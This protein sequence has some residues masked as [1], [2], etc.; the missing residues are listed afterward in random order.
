MSKITLNKEVKLI[1]HFKKQLRPHEEFVLHHVFNNHTLHAPASYNENEICKYATKNGIAPLLHH[2]DATSS[3]TSDSNNYLK[4][5]HYQTLLNNTH[6]YETVKWIQQT[7]KKENINFLFLKGSLLAFTRYKD[8]AL[9]PMSDIDLIIEN[10]KAEKAYSLLMQ[11]GATG[12]EL[13]FTI[14]PNDHHLPP[15]RYNKNLIEVH[16]SLFP[17]NSKFNIKIIHLFKNKL[18][19]QKH[20]TAIEGPSVI[21]TATH[22]ALHLYYTFLRGGLRLSWF[23]D[24]YTLTDDLKTIDRN[25]FLSFSDK[26]Q[27][28]ESLSFVGSF[29][30]LIS[31]KTLPN[32]PLRKNYKPRKIDINRVIESFRANTQQN[33]KESYQLI[34][35]QIREASGIKN[36]ISIIQLRLTKNRSIKGLALIRHTGIVCYR[37]LA[38]AFNNIQK[39]LRIK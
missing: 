29:Y 18:I 10:N 4:Q 34:V 16:Q 39:T 13:P 24:L 19:W 28:T 33:T 21:H 5:R 37:F 14:A 12:R 23:Y 15:L 30:T 35:E 1:Q 38:Y 31:G 2:T 8:S 17:I 27:L 32:W 20:H 22:V 9:R 36:K 6:L 26:N 3:L 11:N 7:L 25:D